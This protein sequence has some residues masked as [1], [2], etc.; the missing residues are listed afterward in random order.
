[1]IYDESNREYVLIG[2]NENYTVLE[3]AASNDTIIISSDKFNSVF[4]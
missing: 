2:A 4:K 1:M 3:C